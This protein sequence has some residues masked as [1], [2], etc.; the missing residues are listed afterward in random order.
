MSRTARET[1]GRR[2]FSDHS[3]I[4]PFT[5]QS[6]SVSWQVSE[7]NCAWPGERG[8]LSIGASPRPPPKRLHAYH[9]TTQ[10]RPHSARAQVT[11][12]DGHDRKIRPASARVSN[13][14]TFDPTLPLSSYTSDDLS[15]LNIHHLRQLIEEQGVCTGEIS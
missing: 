15:S 8:R 6:N 2:A 3:P 14:R 11:R 12:G 5:P 13:Q 4:R 10:R 1:F 9:R 7:M